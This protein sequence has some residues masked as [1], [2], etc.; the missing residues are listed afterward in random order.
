MNMQKLNLNKSLL[1]SLIL[2][3]TL[4]G[5]A[6]TTPPPPS[7]PWAGWNHGTQDFNDGLDKHILKPLAKGYQYI[8]PTFVND[9]ITNFFS[10]INDI[11]VTFNDLFQLK[12]SQ[13]GQ[14]AS[15]FLLNTTAGVGG[16]V[17]VANRLDLP[18]HNEDFGQTL[19]FWGVPSGNYLV[20]PFYGPS[21]P[22]DTLGLIGDAALNPLTYVS[23]FSGGIVNAI[24]GGA[25]AVDVVDH[26]AELMTKEKILDESTVDRYD[27]L[28]SAYQ[29]NREY[30]IN[31]GKNS[32]NSDP[33]LL[34]DN[35]DTSGKGSIGKGGN[36]SGSGSSKGNSGSTSGSKTQSGK[37][38]KLSVPK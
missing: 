38:L 5:C 31:D 24:T 27:S 4:V 12:F 8:T 35:S 18:K 26:R 9:G 28:K 37:S 3:I 29:Q 25:R 15:R 17:D 13:S 36:S 30:L 34:D 16:F 33:D 20:L 22:R 21:S 10:N 23:I 2:S 14:D 11:G 32:N 6:S 19:G 7:D 1:N